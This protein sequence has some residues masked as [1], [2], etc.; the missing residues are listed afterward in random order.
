MRWDSLQA[1]AMSYSGLWTLET[2][3]L[4]VPE[5]SMQICLRQWWRLKKQVGWRTRRRG[6]QI[7]SGKFW[8][9]KSFW[10]KIP[11]CLSEFLEDLSPLSSF[12]F[13]FY[14]CSFCASFKSLHC[15][16]ER[17]SYCRHCTQASACCYKQ[18]DEKHKRKWW[19]YSDLAVFQNVIKA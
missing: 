3:K 10:E 1:W 14:C 12:D 8:R 11:K 18:D 7:Y 16:L 13:C 6:W 2:H 5:R 4:L 15:T 19:N 9:Q 17:I